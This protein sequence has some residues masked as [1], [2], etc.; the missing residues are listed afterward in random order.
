MD[1]PLHAA[2]RLGADR[3]DVAAGAQGHDRL[4]DD[5]GHRG[6]AKHGVEA[7]ADPV[8]RR[9]QALADG[10]EL[11]GG[12][13][14]HLAALV[15][16]ARDPAAPAPAPGRG[17]REPRPGAF[18]ARPADASRTSRSRS[19]VSAI[20]SSSAGVSRPL[21]DRA[22]SS[23]ARMSRAPPIA[24]LRLLAEQPVGLVGLVLEEADVRRIGDR[25]RRQGQLARRA[26]TRS[27]RPA[28]RR[29]RGT[30]ARGAC[31]RRPRSRRRGS[32]RRRETWGSSVIQNRSGRAAQCAGVVDAD[33]RAAADRRRGGRDAA[34]RGPAR[35]E[36]RCRSGSGRRRTRDPRCRARR[37]ADDREPGRRGVAGRASMPSSRASRPNEDRLR[38]L[39]R[40]SDD[41]HAVMEAV[42]QVDVQVT[43]RTEHHR[44]SPRLGRARSARRGPRGRGRPRPPRSGRR[45]THRAPHGPAALPSRSRSESLAAGRSNQSRSSAS[46]RPCRRASHGSRRAAISSG[47]KGRARKPASGDDACRGRSR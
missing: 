21:R 47:T 27:P 45:P 12:R 29:S 23:A 18:R 10:G 38:L 31:P 41:V 4:A 34:R 42:N 44:V 37:R 46:R 40:A 25:E 26:R 1:D 24:G 11:R 36:G 2:L 30:R 32:F 7:L 22:R 19:S 16:A 14:E 13:V 35:R 33:P 39:S 28:A 15:D 20:S 17:R 9:A 3:D 5:P 8:L 43:G 6:R